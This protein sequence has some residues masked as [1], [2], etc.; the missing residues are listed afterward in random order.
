ME[1]HFL[2]RRFRDD[3]VADLKLVKTG[4]APEL[5]DAAADKL[6]LWSV[7]ITKN[8]DDD[9]TP[10]MIDNVSAKDKMKLKATR[11]LS[12]V[13]IEKPLE[14]AIHII[15]QCSP[16]AVDPGLDMTPLYHQRQDPCNSVV[17]ARCSNSYAGRS[18]GTYTSSIQI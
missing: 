3:T 12:D 2:S 11:E 14:G 8:D 1:T 4:K 10:V 15:I 13:F 9:D 5:N 7:S 18:S 16:P 17:A 6:T